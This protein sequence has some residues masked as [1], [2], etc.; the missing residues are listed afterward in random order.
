[1]RVDEQ[2]NEQGPDGDFVAFEDL[3]EHDQQEFLAGLGYPDERK[4]DG[5]D[6]MS[7]SAVIAYTEQSLVE[8]SV[9]VPDPEYEYVRYRENYFRLVKS[10]TE[11]VTVSTYEVRLEQVADSPA[12]LAA[13][14]RERRGVVLDDLTAEQREILDVA[15]EERYDEC[16]E[17]TTATQDL[18]ERLRE[19]DYARYDG[20]WYRVD[21][22]ESV[23]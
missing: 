15:A 3:P 23:A 8:S 2:T 17:Y 12:A 16:A 14:V 18:V 11:E 19:V 20:T 6:S 21:V 5:L 1:M 9:L 4:F 22:Y 13:L 7:G 10:G